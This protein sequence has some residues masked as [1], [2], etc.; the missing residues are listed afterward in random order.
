MME[1]PECLVISGQLNDAVRGK[2][3]TEVIANASPHGFAWFFGD[4]ALYSGLLTGRTLGDARPVG[5][6]VEIAA[7]GVTLLFNDGVNL[8]YLVPGAKRPAKHQLLL[9][10][11]DGSALVC[12]VQMYGGMAAFPDGTN[13]NPYYHVALDKPSPLTDAFNEA[14]FLAIFDAAKPSLSA[15]ALLATEQRMPGL[16]NGVLQ[17]ILFLAGLH[18]QRPISTIDG[19]R[20]RALFR[21]VKDTLRRM[22]D[23]GGRDVEKDIYGKPG[24]YRTLLSRKTVELPCPKCG[25]MITRKAYLGG[26]VYFC[27]TCQPLVKA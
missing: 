17:D 5:G 7:E 19:A 26:N 13:D 18:P 2:R 21:T 8:R 15:K 14:Y 11:E 4:P 1:L 24:G 16:G 25:G 3:I 23:E 20:R 12:S 27:E 6:Q 10:F 9:G 22:A